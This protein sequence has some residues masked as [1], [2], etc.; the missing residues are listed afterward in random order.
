MNR[1]TAFSVGVVLTLTTIGVVNY[2]NASGNQI[3]YSC[4]NKS[5]RVIRY[6]PKKKCARNETSLSWNVSGETGS[7]GQQGIQGP[8]G[9]NGEKGENGAQ[10]P[11]G[12]TGTQG[13]TGPTGAI[14]ATGPQGATG[15]IGPS[16]PAGPSGSNFI[17]QDVCGNNGTSPCTIG[18]IGPGGG[19]IFFID[20][21]GIY[22]HFDYLEVAPNDAS[23]SSVFAKGA[24]A[25]GINLIANCETNLV[26]SVAAA[27]KFQVLG[28]GQESTTRTLE[29]FSLGGMNILGTAVQ[30]ADS[31]ITPTADD[32]YLPTRNELA[33]VYTNIKGAGLGGFS[34]QTYWTSSEIPSSS[35]TDP[36]HAYVI[37]FRSTQIYYFSWK[38]ASNRVRAIRS[39]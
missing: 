8:R 34:E 7:Q 36:S 3:I 15:P 9:L 35:G 37:D 33:L 32:W 22:P 21:S 24:L 6:V 2:A 14:G 28:K 25:C 13:A 38:N 17:S 39:F 16:G 31:Y 1:F 27:Q 18:S 23:A 30:V 5:T 20:T 26:T 11:T 12:L 19:L 4:V 10:G 29:S